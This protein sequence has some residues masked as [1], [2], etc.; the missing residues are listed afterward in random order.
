M[1]R[2]PSKSKRPR[3]RTLSIVSGNSH[4]TSYNLYKL[5]LKELGIDI[6]DQRL[7][8]R[9]DDDPERNIGGS[10]L[11][12]SAESLE[13]IL[14]MIKLP[15][16]LENFIIFGLL[17]C[18]NSFLKMLV[19]LPIKIIIDISV[20]IYK[21]RNQFIIRNNQER[22]PLRDHFSIINSK[23]LLLASILFLAMISSNVDTSRIYHTI[24]AQ[25]SIKLYVMFGVLEI[26][27]KLMATVNQD[28]MNVLFSYNTIL[29]KDLTSLG[30]F[31]LFYGLSVVFLSIHTVIL[32]Y[33]TIALNVAANSYSN[34]LLTL[35]LSNQFAEIKGAVFKKIDREGLFQMSCADV[36]ERFQL[37][38]MLT[39]I[40]LRN[41]VQIGNDSNGI[42]LIPNSSF[43]SWNKA[44]GIIF[45]PTMI[46]IGSELLVDWVK[47]AYVT[48]F[49]KIR[50]QIYSKFL[51]V[52]ANDMVN[53]FK[54]RVSNN[55]DDKIQH[56]IG[57]PLPALFVLF[58]VMSKNTLSWFL[59]DKSVNDSI[60]GQIIWTNL[61]IFIVTFITLVFFKLLIELILIKWAN[62]K[63]KK[64]NLQSKN[65]N[66]E[67][68]YVPGLVSGGMGAIDDE[69]RTLLYDSN[70]TIQPSLNEIRQRKESKTQG[71]LNE[72]TRYRMFS[73]KI[74]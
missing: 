45:G 10:I 46:V 37:L 65:I 17:S 19:I 26:A 64:L 48:K 15:F 34:S 42:G 11:I 53:N 63:L 27:D 20:L 14:N 49:N 18:L 4:S 25:S 61:F 54:I 31:C 38:T 12:S 8:T 2:S 41:I 23:N 39:I 51:N 66:T 40:S 59:L 30:L 9:E 56:R 67:D 21:F 55:N 58:I 6:R 24:R 60:L 29:T 44:L 70:E 22:V 57:L 13:Q 47:H 73:K 71:N 69:S 33:Q 16:Y 28:L 36:V 52:F 35:L 32:I 50:P 3:S 5:L 1:P 43:I 62:Q 72:V 7:K 74:W 68:D